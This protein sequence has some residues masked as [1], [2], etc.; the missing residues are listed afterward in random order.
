MMITTHALIGLL[1]ATGLSVL[2]PGNLELIGLAGIIGGI[3]PDLDMPLSHRKTFHYPF[4]SSVL[5][6]TALGIAIAW[7]GFFTVA[8]AALLLGIALHATMDTIGGDLSKRPWKQESDKAVYDHVR[9]QWLPAQRYIRYDGSPE[10][11]VLYVTLAVPVA[12]I[13]TGM[14]DDLIIAG[15]IVSI[16]YTAFRKEFLKLTPGSVQEPIGL[17]P[18]FL[19][20]KAWFRR[21]SKDF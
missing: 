2:A 20:M 9:H 4:I 15:L 10:D 16:T 7:T 3:L 12:Y 18:F 17:E 19:R 11:L 13:H 14:I 1:A 6:L 21:R 8:V 5:A